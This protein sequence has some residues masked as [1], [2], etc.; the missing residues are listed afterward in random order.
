MLPP[1]DRDLEAMVAVQ[2]A[3]IAE[4]R[5]A[6]AALHTQVVELQVV[7]QALGARV[8]EL[9]GRLGRDSS[10]SST[11]PSQ[12]GLRKPARPARRDRGARRPGKQPGAP[13]AHLAQVADPT[14]WWCTCP[15]GV[16]AAAVT[17]P[18]L[19][20]PGVQARQVWS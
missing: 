13:G 10:N 19:P 1:H 11:P 3:L 20:L 7:N 8:A 17:W 6:N 4:L 14:R 18:M 2:A 15:S 5:T 12:D 9:E 16:R